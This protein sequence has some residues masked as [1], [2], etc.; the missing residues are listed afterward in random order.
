MPLDWHGVIGFDDCFVDVCF[1]GITAGPPEPETSGLPVERR[2]GEAGV[3][4]TRIIAA[5]PPRAAGTVSRCDRG[6]E[7]RCWLTV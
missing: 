5:M 7:V 6:G 3:A 2:T 4:L 1:T